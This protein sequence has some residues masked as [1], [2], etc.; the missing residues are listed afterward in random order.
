MISHFEPAKYLPQITHAGREAGPS[1]RLISRVTKVMVICLA[2][3]WNG[4]LF[5]ETGDDLSKEY[6]DCIDKASRGATAE[7]FECNGE[8][9]DRQDARLN[10]AY[11]RLMSKQSRGQK[12]ALVEAQRAWLKFRKA[13]CDF[14][15]DPNGGSAARFGRELKDLLPPD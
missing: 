12:K 2:V 13:N 4:Q 14:Y 6:S 5:A 1:S 3:L 15:Y 10:D 7:M 11:K 9:L 8:E